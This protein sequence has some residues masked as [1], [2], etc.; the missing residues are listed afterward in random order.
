MINAEILRNCLKDPEKAVSEGDMEV[1]MA[2]SPL[3]HAL[4]QWYEF[5][6]DARLLELNA[7]WGAMTGLFLDRV[8]SVTAAAGTEEQRAF[9]AE[10]FRNVPLIEDRLKILSPETAGDGVPPGKGSP[11]ETGFDY[12]VAE[13]LLE[14]AEDPAGTL[15]GWMRLLKPG[16]TLLV[17]AGNRYGLKYFCGA[18]DPYTGSMYESISRCLP[19]PGRKGR[20]LSRKELSRAVKTAGIPVSRFYFPVPDGRMPQMIFTEEYR[21]GVNAG[22]GLVD[23]DYED[24]AM[25]GLEHRIFEDMIDEGALPFLANTFLLELKQ[26]GEVSDILYAVLTGDRG[27]EYGM[28]TTV[29]K[30]GTVKKRPLFQEGKSRLQV[31]HSHTQ[32]LLSCGVPV[33]ETTLGEDEYGPV[34]SMPF[35]DA[36]GLSPVLGRL[37]REDRDRFLGI[38]D[39]IW[40]YIGRPAEAGKGVFLDLAPCNC[41]YR[42]DGS[43]LFY[44]QEFTAEDCR[45]EFGMFRTLK[46]WYASMPG[47][48][49]VIPLRDMYR[50]YGIDEAAERRFEEREQSFLA[51]VRPPDRNA[52]LLRMARPD[53]GAA[54]R[55][56]RRLT[57]EALKDPGASA[58]GDKPYKVGYVPGVFDLLHS[59]H[60]R[61]LERCKER[62]EYLIVGVLT[63][64]L[65]LHYKGRKPVMPYA[66][67]ARVIAA[68]KVTDEVVP[69]DFSN[70]NQLDAWDQLHYDCHFSGDDHLGHWD[71]VHAELRKRG[72]EM[73]F[74]SYT[75]GISSTRIRNSMK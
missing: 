29:R 16:G 32:K 70:T 49:Q 52:S 73:E 2:L 15:R 1:Q 4:F 27:K 44:D 55:K 34:L 41:F 28:A 38:F 61:L 24:P 60:L 71:D 35:I 22:E 11:D 45:E 36:E 33:V 51:A 66:E 8:K 62:C 37:I 39:R 47:A 20:L 25:T 74:F 64:E 23:Y 50:R 63:D 7:G 75:Q 13:G 21:K 67:R 14:E 40:G 58:A 3:R 6:K 30:D 10:R 68:L 26:E 53:P 46:Y 9:I 54:A 17:T 31:L 43:L 72:S 69:V 19:D 42:E 65:V 48:D 5:R 56:M 18:R 59:G 12:V 57:E